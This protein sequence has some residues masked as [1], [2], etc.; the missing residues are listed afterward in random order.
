VDTGVEEGGEVSPF[1]DPMIA[2]I[3]L[4]AE[5][6]EV[7]ADALADEC[8][9][10]ECWPVKTNASFLVYAL[11]HRD[12]VDGSVDTGFIARCLPEWEEFSAT[13]HVISEQDLSYIGH[14]IIGDKHEQHNDV[15]KLQ[16]G[17]RLNAQNTPLAIRLTVGEEQHE[18]RL[19]RQPAEEWTNVIKRDDGY[20]ISR[21]NDTWHVKASRTDGSAH[22]PASNG[23]IISP[24]PGRII[25]VEVAAGD[26]VTKGQK[27]LT[28]EAMKM[29]HSLTAPFDGVI[30]ELNAEVGAQVQVEALLVR[31]EAAAD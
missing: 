2:K 22:G 27:L 21:F 19:Q 7:A 12:F 6:R 13:N 26:T 16:T 23:A 10:V 18:V 29:E 20:L 9:T 17:T 8:L 4:W 24:M 14:L 15:W 5:N 1:Y 25:A 31:I 30:A 28:L 3:V 11:A